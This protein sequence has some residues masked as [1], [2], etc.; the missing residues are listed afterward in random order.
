GLMGAL[1]SLKVNEDEKDTIA[2]TL[3]GAES[4]EEREKILLAYAKRRGGPCKT[5]AEA[6]EFF[7]KDASKFTKEGADRDFMNA[8][9]DGKESEAAAASIEKAQKAGNLDTV[10]KEMESPIDDKA[11]PE[12]KKKQLEEHQKKMADIEKVWAEK[13]GTKD[14]DGKP[15]GDP[16]KEQFS[17]MLQKAAGGGS[18][19]KGAS[20]AENLRL[21]TVADEGQMDRQTMISYARLTNKPEMLKKAM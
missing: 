16:P 18:L 1:S 10:V 6:A 4:P 19:E 21:Q 17:D 9:A 13:Y 7:K 2:S 11:S 14:K 5:P 12:E 15:T 8:V 20:S 3:R